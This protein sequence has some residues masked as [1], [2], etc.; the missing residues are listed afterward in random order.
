MKL[1]RTM[2]FMPGNN[3]H[4]LLNADI[5]KAD[6]VVFDLEDAVTVNEKDAARDLVRNA[7][8]YNK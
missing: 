3:P 7:L 1:R 8:K 2:L 4:M 6:S 5:Y